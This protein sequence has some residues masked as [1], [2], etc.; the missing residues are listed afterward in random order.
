MYTQLLKKKKNTAAHTW[1]RVVLKQPANYLL[2]TIQ[3]SF[4]QKAKWTSFKQPPKI[5]KYFSNSQM[6]GAQEIVFMTWLYFNGTKEPAK[7]L[8]C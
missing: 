8:Q 5:Y 6:H 3:F 1:L 2:N 4:S 7:K